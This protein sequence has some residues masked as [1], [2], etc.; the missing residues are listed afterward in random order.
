MM[1]FISTLYI[2]LFHSRAR[3]RRTAFFLFYVRFLVDQKPP[4]P[5][6][7]GT[8][9]RRVDTAKMIFPDYTAAKPFSR[10]AMMSSMCS[11]PMDKRM[12]F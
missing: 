11:V 6:G 5:K 12:V 1:L 3:I 9:C 7:G 10:S 2:S 8:K 4:F